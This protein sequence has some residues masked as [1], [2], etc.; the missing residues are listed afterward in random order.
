MTNGKNK[1]RTPLAN[2][3]GLGSAKEGVNHWVWQRLTAMIVAPLSLW[4][5]FSIMKF[6]QDETS[7]YMVEWMRNPL[8]AMLSFLLIGALFFHANL[9]IQVIIEDYVHNHRLKIIGLLASKLTFLV[10]G[11]ISIM[12]IFSLHFMG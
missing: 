5:L 8:N 7:F 9:G 11:L 12:S 6:T 3:R 1:Y 10:A 2:A 4:F